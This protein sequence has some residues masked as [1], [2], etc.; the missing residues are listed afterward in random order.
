MGRLEGRSA[1]VTGAGSG[2][3][4]ATALAFAREGAAI[5]ALIERDAGRLA[6]ARADVE[7][8]G[9]RPVSVVAD[10]GSA[11]QT[12]RAFGE[13]MDQLGRIDILVSNHAALVPPVE[14]IDGT[15]E[16][17][18][19]Q[20]D[21]N[22]TSHYVLAREAARA[23]RSQA[24]GSILFTASVNALGA[25]RGSG[26]Y[27]VTKAGL[28]ALTRVLAAELAPHGIRVNCVSPG[29]ADTR[30]SVELVG[31]E[32]MDRFRASFPGVPLGRLASAEDIAQA[33][34][35]LASDSAGYVTGHNLIV[36]GGLTTLIYEPPA[37]Q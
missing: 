4:H 6:V 8:I 23:M 21:V 32:Q 31:E 18:A 34:L 22:L 17:W 30:R 12:R 13:A 19:L 5:V 24:S 15:D 2:F 33:F 7:R 26:P 36:D 1:I 25:G 16:Q 28:V 10:L 27:V 20:L 35:Y 11:D 14:L 9:C 37:Q 3:G 29:P